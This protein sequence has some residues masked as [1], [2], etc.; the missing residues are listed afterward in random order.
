MSQRQDRNNWSD[1]LSMHLAVEIRARI[2]CDAQQLRETNHF[3]LSFFL[4]QKPNAADLN[5]GTCHS[6]SVSLTSPG[7]F[8]A[9]LLFTVAC[10]ISETFGSF[11]S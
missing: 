1:T 7:F 8:D 5:L 10:K 9:H 11:G 2:L 4:F 3:S 6:G